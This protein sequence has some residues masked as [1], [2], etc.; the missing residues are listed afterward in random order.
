MR[1]VIFRTKERRKEK[2]ICLPLKNDFHVVV[3]T[4]S[5]HAEISDVGKK[6]NNIGSCRGSKGRKIFPRGVSRPLSRTVV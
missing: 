2:R 3:S 6:K 1:V 5:R 4:G